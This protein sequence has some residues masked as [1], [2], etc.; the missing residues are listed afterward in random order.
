MPSHRQFDIP[1]PA[2]RSRLCCDQL[3]RPF[4]EAVETGLLQSGSLGGFLAGDAGYE[5][6]RFTLRGAADGNATVRLA[7]DCER[8]VEAH[9]S[10][11]VAIIRRYRG[12][13]SVGND[14]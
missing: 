2:A 6:H 8:Q 5:L 3:L 11:L 9:L 7:A 1:F 12:M 13:L 4:W 14:I 10:A